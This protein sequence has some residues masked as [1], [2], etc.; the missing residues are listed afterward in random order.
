MARSSNK[1]FAGRMD[2][3]TRSDCYVEVEIRRGGGVTLVL[4]SKVGSLYGESIRS[5][6]RE[7]CPALG[8]TDAAF[9]IIDQGA[10]PYVLAAR[11]ETAVKRA[12]PRLTSEFLPPARQHRKAVNPKGRHRRT[13]LYLP[14]TE[15]K[16]F[17]NAG[18][19]HPDMIVLDLE[20]SVAP[21]EKDSARLLVRNALR[22]LD[23]YGAER[24]VRINQ[25]RLGRED[26]RTI[27]PQK[28]DIILLPKCE[29]ADTV[30]DVDREIRSL[31]KRGEAGTEILLLPIIE[32]ALGV[33]N[34]YAIASASPRVCA[35]AIGLEDYTADIGVERTNDGRE[36]LFARMTIMNAAKAAGVQALDS[37]T[38]DVDDLEGLSA[39]TRESRALG[40]DGKGCIH[41]RQIKVIHSAFEPAAHEI[42]KAKLI[43][44][45]AEEARRLGS[46]VVAMGTKMIDAPVV[47]RAER[48]LRL[49]EELEK[50]RASQ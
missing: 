30:R 19:H 42:E 4:E 41:P 9:R 26:I 31:E 12:L 36:S 22:V 32:S 39:S 29:D 40:F 43:V 28:P 44:A 50:E 18:L 49:A 47:I 14:G 13:R 46:G 20:D 5:L 48:V 7:V 34:A 2:A 24:G 25:G 35:L 21:A 27:V 17:P 3:S 45:A 38:S 1:F 37:V 16:F 8:I 6:L 23:F 10:L 15:P 33:V 11:I